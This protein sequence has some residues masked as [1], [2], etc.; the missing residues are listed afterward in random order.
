MRGKRKDQKLR[1]KAKKKSNMV[2]DDKIRGE[3]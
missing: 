2:I 3:K 1:K